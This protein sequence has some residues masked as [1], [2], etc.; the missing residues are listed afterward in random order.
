MSNITL[1]EY[2]DLRFTNI[3]KSTVLALKSMDKRLD[4]MNEFRY[5]LKDQTALFLT[6]DYYEARHTEVLGQIND[7]KLSRATLEGKAS[8]ISM[9][10]AIAISLVGLLIGLVNL[11][12]K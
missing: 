3:D 6:K 8:A 5:Q 1:R 9:Y 11:L 10:T 12:L 4:S 7:L 2:V